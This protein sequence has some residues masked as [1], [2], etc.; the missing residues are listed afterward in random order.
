MCCTSGTQCALAVV[1]VLVVV[2]EKVSSRLQGC[3]QRSIQL[4]RN[5]FY[6]GR[7]IFPLEISVILE[8][9]KPKAEL[10]R[11]MNDYYFVKKKFFSEFS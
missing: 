8:L 10:H 6:F 9:V 7:R 1:L 4:L 2:E 3:K 5:V 11:K